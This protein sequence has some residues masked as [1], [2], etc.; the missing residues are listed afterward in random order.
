MSRLAKAVSVVAVLAVTALVWAGAEDMKGKDA[1][2]VKLKTPSGEAFD[3]SECKAKG[4]GFDF[5]ASWC[6]PC[7]K[8]L[9]H[10]QNVADWAKQNK[11]DVVFYAI[12]LQEDK[13]KIDQ[14]WK[15]LKMSL[16]AL[17]DTDGKVAT[18]YKVEAIPTTLVI[19]GGKVQWVHVAYTDSLEQD[20]KDA[21]NKQL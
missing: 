1:P 19:A 4:G 14:A 15:E 17:M 6:P 5:W 13:A 8:G 16:P 9:P 21:I 20:L 3:L 2:N 12:N 10:V 7:R 18:A 11:K